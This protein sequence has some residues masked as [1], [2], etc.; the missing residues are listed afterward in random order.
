[1]GRDLVGWGQGNRRFQG[2]EYRAGRRGCQVWS[3]GRKRPDRHLKSEQWAA[4]PA[5]L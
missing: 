4:G 2:W 5:I 1:M 3:E